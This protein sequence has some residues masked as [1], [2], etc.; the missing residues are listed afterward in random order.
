MEITRQNF[1]EKCLLLNHEGYKIVGGINQEIIMEDSGSAAACATRKVIRVC[2]NC[3][4]SVAQGGNCNSVAE[5]SEPATIT[6]E[7]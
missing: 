7:V 2:R 6:A 1:D 3:G 5:T 4:G